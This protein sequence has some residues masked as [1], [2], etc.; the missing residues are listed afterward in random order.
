[1]V[2]FSVPFDSIPTAGGQ[3]ATV[4]RRVMQFLIPGL[5]GIGAVAFDR[6][7]YKLPDTLT[8]EVADS[9][10]ANQSNITVNVFSDSVPALVPITLY[11]TLRAGVFRGTTILTNMSAAPGAGIL[12][13]NN[14]DGIYARYFDTSGNNN[15]TATAYVDSTAPIISGVTA[16]ADYESVTVTWTTSEDTDALIQ[17]GESPFLGRTAYVEDFETTHVVT[18][19]GLVPNQTYYFRVISSDPA[20][21]TA[22]DDNHGTN[23]VV[24][25]LVPLTPPFVDHFDGGANNWTVFNGEDTQ[26]EWTLGVPNNDLATAAYSPP[27]AWGSSLNNAYADYID[28]FL[29][30]PAIQLTGGNSAHLQFQHAWDFSEQNEFDLIT[31][32]ELLLIT[33]ANEAPVELGVWFDASGGWVA[34]DIDL[35]QY[36]G[37]V[38]YLVWHH[39]LFSF[40]AA[41]RPGWL[42]DDVSVTMTTI[43]P[44]TLRMTNNLSQASFAITGPVNVTG[45][46]TSFMMTNAPPGSYTVTWGM[47]T[48]WNTPAPQTSSVAALGTTVFTGTY[49]ITDTNGNGIADSWERTYF[50]GAAVNHPGSLD[51]DHDGMSDYGEFIAGTNPTNAASV[52]RYFSPVVQNT[53]AVR[54]DWPTVPGRSYRVTTSGST[55][56][57]WTDATGWLRANGSVLSFSTNLASGPRYFRVEVKP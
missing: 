30:S 35:S 46:G 20:G 45:Q 55:L 9:D 37:R 25:T 36:I 43:T 1:M 17:F 15:I 7:E 5:D 13:A 10:L 11:A 2:F 44:G 29:I 23:Y 47:V 22:V 57:N 26:S 48:N 18:L 51:T 41:T 56:T 33:N 12:R 16:E 32:G 53:G 8:I 34:E 38:V 24:H 6:D 14:G 49:G 27:N 42:L 39:Q 19:G 31:G 52:L 21:N 50:G 40:E 28:T 3:R 4:L 54:L